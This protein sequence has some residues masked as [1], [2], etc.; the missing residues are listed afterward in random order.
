MVASPS[1]CRVFCPAVLR[2]GKSTPPFPTYTPSEATSR[3][4]SRRRC[5]LNGSEKW[6]SSDLA[7]YVLLQDG[8]HVEWYVACDQGA[9]CHAPCRN[10]PVESRWSTSA[11]A[12][13]RP[14]LHIVYA[15]RDSA[16]QRTTGSGPCM[17]R[18]GRACV[19]EEVFSF[20]QDD[21]SRLPCIPSS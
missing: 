2:S 16:C 7:R 11:H 14:G 1:L 6:Y 8:D 12:Q 20:Q 10:Q 9:A 19:S 4:C 21:T 13:L 17:Y 3:P 18:R 5:D 15:S